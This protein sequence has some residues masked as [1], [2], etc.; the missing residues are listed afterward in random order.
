MSVLRSPLNIF[1]PANYKVFFFSWGLFFSVLAFLNFIAP[2][3]AL[4]S[5]GGIRSFT[6]SVLVSFVL[7]SVLTMFIVSVFYGS[8]CES[9]L[10]KAA[11]WYFGK[12]PPLSDR[13]R[14][15]I[16]RLR[17][18]KSNMKEVPW[19]PEDEVK[20]FYSA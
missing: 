2:L 15:S 13:L 12:K 5:K 6:T 1:F 18:M 4:N 7:Y 3:T 10:N 17:A 11:Q 8:S 14:P 16:E 20:R 19:E 9:K